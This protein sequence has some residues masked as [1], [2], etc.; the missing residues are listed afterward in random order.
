L[1]AVVWVVQVPV[2]FPGARDDA[3]RVALQ[4]VPGYSDVRFT[5]HDGV[6]YNGMMYQPSASP[7]G[8]IV[9]FG[10]NGEVSYTTFNGHRVAG[11]WDE[12][13]GYAMLYMDYPGYGLNTGQAS[14]A[15]IY[16][17]SLAVYDYQRSFPDQCGFSPWTGPATTRCRGL[18][19]STTR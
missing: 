9:Y 1:S 8:L 14:Q 10:G 19:A 16:A 3:S 6:T 4:G 2:M 15:T 18:Q 7:P 17:E 5:S 13:D 11:N 12:Y